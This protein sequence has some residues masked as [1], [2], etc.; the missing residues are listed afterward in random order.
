[1]KHI[2][3]LNPAAGH[4]A[5]EKELLPKV[6][7]YLKENG[8]EYE[9][10]RSLNKQ[11]VGVW[12]RQ[13]AAAG[14][15]VR[16]YAMGGDGTICDVLGGMIGYANAELA[17]MPCGTGNDFVRN[18]T[19]KEN[20][21]KIDKLV[22]GRAE[23]IDAIR[24]NGKY[25]LNMLNIGADC[26]VVVRVGELKDR[27]RGPLA[28][29]VGALEILPKHPS[30][31]MTY[32]IDGGEEVTEDLLLVA[33][34][35]GMF[36]GGGFKSC[37]RSSLNDGKMDITIA[38]PVSGLKLYP[39][40]LKYHNGTHIT[41][42]KMADYVKYLQVK[43]FTIRPNTAIMLSVD[44]EVYPLEETKISVVPKAVRFV[45]P[46]GSDFAADR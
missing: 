43:E 19:N 44:G 2:F 33:I 38:R 13:R 39:M 3:I 6:I 5:A 36:C 9:I 4:G 37:P 24:Y 17:V 8:L 34:A 10:H 23:K 12:T 7:P 26:Q 32:S 11:E 31:S 41:D 20:F 42:P 40:L 28:Y 27:I 29:A 35:N 22:N 46:E 21:I 25:A 14:D 15:P 16:F 18:F 30:Y 45:I 1:M